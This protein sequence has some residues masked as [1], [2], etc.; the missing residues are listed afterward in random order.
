MCYYSNIFTLGAFATH[1]RVSESLFPGRGR[2][3]M[4][5][6]GWIDQ[7]KFHHSFRMLC[8]PKT[9][10][11]Y[12]MPEPRTCWVIHNFPAK[13]FSLHQHIRTGEFSFSLGCQPVTQMLNSDSEMKSE[14]RHNNNTAQHKKSSII[15]ETLFKPRSHSDRYE[16][17]N[18]P[19]SGVNLMQSKLRQGRNPKR[20]M[21]KCKTIS[22]HNSIIH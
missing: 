14:E 10:H 13:R 11:I 1:T 15:V 12:N 18:P 20:D 16:H 6:D 5:F 2:A 3:S 7:L 8:T 21:C 4:N 9:Q 17:L 22:T 19:L